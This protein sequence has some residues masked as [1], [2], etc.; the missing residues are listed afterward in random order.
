MGLRP[1]EA[2]IVADLLTACL[3]AGCTPAQ[4]ARAVAEALGGAPAALLDEVAERLSAGDEPAL[5]WAGVEAVPA[6]AAIGR[7]MVRSAQ[8]GVAVAGVVAAEATRVRARRRDESTAALARL[9]T[10][11]AVP[12]ALCF[13]PAFVCLG[14]IPVVVGLATVVLEGGLW[15]DF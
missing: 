7:A 14:V 6:L 8:T 3:S 12:L 4:A 13:L 10:F 2:A 9:S 1:S 5:A 11:A 15:T